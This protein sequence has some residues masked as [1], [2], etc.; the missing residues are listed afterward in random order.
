MIAQPQGLAPDP[1][2]DQG[3]AGY[4][5]RLRSGATSAEAATRA[6][7]DRI[8]RLDGRLQSY[9]HVAAPA[10]LAQ[11]RAIDRLLAAGVDL[12]PLMGVP[13]SVK[14]LFKIDGMPVYAGSNI[15]V[16]DVI[17]DEGLFVKSLK[18]SGCVILGTVKTP[19]FAMGSAG[20]GGVAILRGAPWNPWDARVHRGPG[21]SSSGSGVAVAAG[22]CA[23]SIGT[24]TGGS[25]RSPS[26]YCG[27]FGLKTSSGRFPADGLFPQA[28]KLDSIG[29]LT[30]SAADAALV[31]G[32][33]TGT[34]APLPRDPRT[35]RLGRLEPEYFF[36]ELQA[37]VATAVEGA[38]AALEKAGIEIAPASF[39]EAR[40]AK[41]RFGRYTNAELISVIGRERF[42][43]E[44]ARMD[45]IVGPRVATALDMTGDEYAALELRRRELGRIAVERLAEVDAW[46]LP[47]VAM[48]APP[49]HET[50]GKD[51]AELNRLLATRKTN[52]RVF[53]NVC[54]LVA[55]S[56]PVQRFG[57]DLPVGLQIV[58]KPF[59][60]AQVLAIALTVER[61]LG[62]PPRPDV[63][64]FL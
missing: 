32:A 7:L 46:V 24:D 21:V 37:P 18:K 57:A 54:N 22:L 19:E 14:D 15:D 13:I 27:V 17:G 16:T 59:A 20:L 56:T 9:E 38:L 12:G 49:M 51:P 2:D 52:R 48:V 63:R 31:F 28:R 29:P 62:R 3:I 61:I 50:E 34:P 4:G 36:A 41:D 42:V 39:P 1:L 5:K 6:Y 30:R 47:T 10:A 64:G 33:L 26:S 60:E 23:F 45:P 55:T 35:I 53:A 25:V 40:E 8:A 43:R 11:A 58:C 44:R